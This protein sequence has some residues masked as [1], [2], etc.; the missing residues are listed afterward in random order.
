MNKLTKAIIILIALVVSGCDHRFKD[1]DCIY[2]KTSDGTFK[3]EFLKNGDG[4]YWYK[5]DGNIESIGFGSAYIA[6]C[7]SLN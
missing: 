1:G 7:D 2:L 3:A 5:R 4:A 6:S